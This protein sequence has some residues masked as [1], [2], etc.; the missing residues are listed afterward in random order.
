MRALF[1]FSENPSIT[2]FRPHVARTSGE[3][4]P[5]VWALDEEHAPSYW[6]P[7]DCPRACCWANEKPISAA[8]AALLDPG[9]AHRLHAIEI[10][11][12]KRL[13]G[14]RLYAYEFDPALFTSKVAEA[15]Y[16]VAQ[17]EVVPLALHPVGDLL[18]RHIEEGIEMRVVK[19]L[20]PLIDAIIVSGLEFSIIRSANARRRCTTTVQRSHSVS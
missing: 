17:C 16:W 20:W 5:F 9:G 6:F 15:G 2:V 1:H 19:N 10:E 11:W 4:E 13:R 7:R 12:L 14:C 3:T 8:G 18:E